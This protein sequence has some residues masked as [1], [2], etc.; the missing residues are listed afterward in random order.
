MRLRTALEI[1]ER[2]QGRKPAT[3]FLGLVLCL[4]VIST[5]GPSV[6]TAKS[7]KSDKIDGPVVGIDLGTTYSAV[8]IYKNGRT[9]VI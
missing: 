2:K 1:K 5:H 3:Q 6:A 7:T 4:M 9:E 8:A